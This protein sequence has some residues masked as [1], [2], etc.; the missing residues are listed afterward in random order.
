M[1]A[2]IEETRVD[3]NRARSF[4][5][6]VDYQPVNFAQTLATA[7]ENWCAEFD[8]HSRPSCMIARD[9]KHGFT[10]WYTAPARIWHAGS[11]VAYQIIVQDWVEETTRRGR[12][13][14]NVQ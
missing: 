5:A 7:C 4:R 6:G 1:L 11:L 3:K 8:L 13:L 2:A 12:A 10:D 9:A 14:P